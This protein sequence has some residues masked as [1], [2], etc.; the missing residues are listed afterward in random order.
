MPPSSSEPPEAARPPGQRTGGLSACERSWAAWK[1]L[2]VG[3]IRLIR[4]EI[5]PPSGVGYNHG[6]A[7]PEEVIRQA[8]ALSQARGAMLLSLLGDF[9]VWRGDLAEMRGDS[10]RTEEK[11]RPEQPT[12]ANGSTLTDVL[13][14]SRAIEILDIDCRTALSKVYEIAQGIPGNKPSG[15]MDTAERERAS[16]CKHRLV[17]LYAQLQKQT[18]GSAAPEWVAEREH[19]VI[20]SRGRRRG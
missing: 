19:A 4:A 3:K 12:V 10:P 2:I 8:F 16:A 20:A 15:E 7:I 9:D 1:E 13:L 11:N 5:T 6:V 18:T 14:M 17:E